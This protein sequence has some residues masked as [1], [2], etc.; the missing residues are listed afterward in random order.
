MKYDPTLLDAPKGEIIKFLNVIEDMQAGN[1]EDFSCKKNDMRPQKF[2]SILAACLEQRDITI[3]STPEEKLYEALFE[4]VSFTA[5]PSDL[6]KTIPYC[7]EQFLDEQERDILRRI[8]WDN[9]TYE[10]ISAAYNINTSKMKRIAHNALKKLKNGTAMKY[11]EF[12]L[13]YEEDL[14]KIRQISTD[15]GRSENVLRLIN[16]LPKE[17]VLTHVQ[18]ALLQKIIS[19]VK[20]LKADYTEIYDDNSSNV[21]ADDEIEVTIE[22]YDNTSRPISKMRVDEM[23][24][25]NRL[26]NTLKKNNINTVEELMNYSLAELRQMQG[27]GKALLRALVNALD[28]YDIKLI[29]M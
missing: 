6:N 23:E 7:M 17:I 12:G 9:E 26:K 25:P 5:Y 28:R 19:L 1:E 20:Q 3:N 14:E 11:I 10:S 29:D 16:N 22:K 2:R 21:V 8:Y 27:M 24:L 13:T 15:E 4:T 18:A